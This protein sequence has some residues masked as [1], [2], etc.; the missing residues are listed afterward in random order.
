MGLELS[1]EAKKLLGKKG[2]DPILGARPLRRTIQRDIEDHL[3]QKI[4]CGELRAGHT[5]VVGVEGE[6]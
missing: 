6:G 1:L 2:Y 5:V 4:L 3:S